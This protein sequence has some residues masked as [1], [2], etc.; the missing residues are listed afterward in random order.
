MSKKTRTHP[1]AKHGVSTHAPTKRT[2]GADDDLS[3]SGSSDSDGHSSCD[4]GDNNGGDDSDIDTPDQDEDVIRVAE[5][6]QEEDLAE[7]EQ[8]AELTVQ[9][10]NGEQKV[11]STALAKVSCTIASC[12]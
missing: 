10:T 6:A 11:A 2:R 9:V 8:L 5:A 12:G 7:A 3:S 1:V 4:D